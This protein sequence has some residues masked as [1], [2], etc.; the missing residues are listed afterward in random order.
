M[1]GGGKSTTT[2][3]STQQ[4]PK[5]IRDR[6]SAITNAAM[7]TYMPGGQNAQLPQYNPYE[8]QTE[9][10][11]WSRTAAP[12]YYHNVAGNKV[13]NAQNSYQPYFNNA[14]SAASGAYGVM[15]SGNQGKPVYAS[16]GATYDAD[17]T[18]RGPEFN[19]TNLQRFQDP[20]NNMVTQSGVQELYRQHGIAQQG[21]NDAAAKAGAFG[22]ARH[23]VQGA[24]TTRAFLDK[25]NQ[26]LADSLQRGYDAA[27]GQYNREKD[28]LFQQT[29]LNNQIGQQQFAQYTG[30]ANLLGDLG[31]RQ[32]SADL[33]A[34]QGALGF[35]QNLQQTEQGALDRGYEEYNKVLNYPI[36]MGR[37]LAAMNAMQPTNRVSTSWSQTQTPGNALGAG[38]GAFGQIAP[39]FFGSDERIKED[40]REEDPEKVLKGFAELPAKSYRYKDKY[41]NLPTT[42]EG[43][44]PGFLAQ[45]Y[46]KA[47]GTK[48]AEIDGIKHIDVSE[49]M[50]RVTLAI[51]GLEK[52]TRPRGQK[53]AR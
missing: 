31:T 37:E 8:G 44:R 22:G 39:M 15:S 24:E 3:Q 1:G 36:E 47:F 27:T 32:L 28:A 23:G 18:A 33:Q 9:V 14:Q 21:I 49:L 20:Y 40:I 13:Q 45:D 11:G 51:K 34:A 6:G 41:A 42:G 29:Q 25:G 19:Q 5:E 10:A 12:N 17:G 43:R 35:G 50:G 46:E 7:S 52:R 2:T 30:L 26:F 53:A 16:T 48:A 4:I 38:L